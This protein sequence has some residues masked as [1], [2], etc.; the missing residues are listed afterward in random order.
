MQNGSISSSPA[1]LT[2]SQF[3]DRRQRASQLPYASTPQQAQYVQRGPLA[4]GF[5]DYDPPPPSPRNWTGI[6]V[7]TLAVV[8][9]MLF[10]I[11]GFWL[12]A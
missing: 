12:V 7:G 10:A 5:A 6:L 3:I 9:T 1:A 11:L 8:L 2:Q 4:G